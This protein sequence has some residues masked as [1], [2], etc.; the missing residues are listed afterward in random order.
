MALLDCTIQLLHLD[1]LKPF[2]ALYGHKLPVLC[3][4]VSSDSLLLVS[5]GGDKNV[6]LWGLD[7][8]DCHKSLL[9][10]G[11][12]VTA[13]RFVPGSHYF[14]SSGMWGMSVGGVE[15]Y[16]VAGVAVGLRG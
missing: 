10:H 16:L 1:T 13:V 4:D 8:G 11:D 9:A 15:G 7:F 12:T 3:M 6:R 2:L 14:F 5:G